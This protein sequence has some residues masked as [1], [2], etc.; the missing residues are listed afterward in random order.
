[1]KK[2]SKKTEKMTIDDLAVLFNKKF[3]T[4]DKKFAVI[5][6]KFDTVDKR[7][8]AVDKRFDAVDKKFDTVDKRSDGL[9]KS[10]DDLAIIVANGFEVMGK[11]IIK[12]HESD[13]NIRQDI[14]NLGDRF[15]S[16][17]SFDNLSHRVYNLEK[18]Q[19]SKK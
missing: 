5:D 17:T 12:L 9:E 10:I 1:M 19:I 3:D 11:E 6:K 7:F 18:K 14:F 15:P 13:R 8:D 16:Q 4:V 2:S